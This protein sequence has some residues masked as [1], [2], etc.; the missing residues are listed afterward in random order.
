MG[1]RGPRPQPTGLRLLRGNPGK[2]PLNSREPT[3][4][5]G[6][7]ACPSWISEEAKRVWRRT[8][9]QLDAMGVI[10]KVDRD[11]LTSYCVTF[12]RWREMEE[13]IKESG[14]M[15]ALRDEKG[16]VRCM[17]QY[18]QVSIAR[19]LLLLVRAYQQEFGMT[20]S[21]RSGI[22]SNA[23]RIEDDEEEFFGP[24]PVP[25]PPRPAT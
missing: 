14:V 16:A 6:A 12:A 15:Y 17:Q 11:A 1:K 24:Q 4:E 8:V 3:P 18:P 5:P 9:K 2:R 21:S 19:Q 22:V 23:P 13:F 10:T 25:A 7:P 20:P